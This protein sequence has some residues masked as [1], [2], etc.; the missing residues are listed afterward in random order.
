MDRS[1][2]CSCVFALFLD[3]FSTAASV[4]VVFLDTFLN[5]WL[6]TSRH[7]YLSRIIE[8]LYKGQARSE[9]HFLSISLSLDTSIFSPPKSLSLAPNHFSS[10]FQAFSRFFFNFM[11]FHVLKP[12]FWGF[13][14]ILGFFKIDEF[15]LK[16]G[17]SF[18]LH[19]FKISYIAFHEHYNCI[20]MHLV[21][22]YTCW[23]ACVLLGLDW[24]EPMMFFTLH[25]TCS[26]I[27][28]HTFFTFSI[29]LYIW[30]VWSFSDCLFLPF[31]SFRLC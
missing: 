1:S 7:F 6:D 4:D 30:T 31:L 26:C 27:F 19:E 3:T 14:K 25:V 8:D 17:M 12:R 28:M 18:S 11:H 24:A 21:V 13:W 9:L 15:L 16:F 10:D 5:R 29:F 2:F 20:F 22:C 23:T